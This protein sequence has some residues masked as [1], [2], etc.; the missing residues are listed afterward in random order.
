MQENLLNED[1]SVKR[2]AADWANPDA[3]EEEVLPLGRPLA[4]CDRLLSGREARDRTV[5][6]SAAG[7]RRAAP[8]RWPAH[9][10]GA[11]RGEAA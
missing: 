3:T 10:S 1:R 9:S 7:S 6:L 5:Q 2:L 11:S 4:L 8:H